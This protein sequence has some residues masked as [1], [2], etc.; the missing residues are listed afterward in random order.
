MKIM[1]IIMLSIIC[2]CLISNIFGQDTKITNIKFVSGKNTLYGQVSVPK[3]K[4]NVPLIIFL[5][6]SGDTSYRTDYK[7]FLGRTIEAAFKKDF[8]LLYFDKPGIGQSMGE[9]WNQDFYQ[10]A[11]NSLNALRYAI[12]KFPIDKSKVGIV[13]HSQGGWLAQ[14]DKY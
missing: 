3:N 1:K 10:Q 7:E 14:I 8:A 4:K 2:L 5:P 9:W 11:E 12:K 13:G 6:G